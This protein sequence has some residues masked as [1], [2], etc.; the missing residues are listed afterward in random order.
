VSL[1]ATLVL[2]GII[3]Y[4]LAGL[5][6][7]VLFVIL[8]VGRVLP[9]PATVSIPARILLIPGAAALWPYVLGR[10]VQSAGRS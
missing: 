5:A 10:W 9:Q 8:G 7:A 3:A 1:G 2:G 6:T 4:A